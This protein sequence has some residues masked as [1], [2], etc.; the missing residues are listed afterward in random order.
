MVGVSSE[1]TQAER[2]RVDVFLWRRAFMSRLGPH[3][4]C[5]AVLNGLAL[6]MDDK[7]ASCFPSTKLLE[8]ETGLSER[9][10]CTHLEAADRDGWVDRSECGM[11]GQKWSRHQ[12][13]ATL[14]RAVLDQLATPVERAQEE[15]FD[16][17]PTG[18][19]T[20]RGSV[21]RG[22]GTEPLSMKALKEVQSNSTGNSTGTCNASPAGSVANATGAGRRV[23][24]STTPANGER[25]DRS[26][27]PPPSSAPASDWTNSRLMGLVRDHLYTPDRKA[28]A[29][30]D[31][32]RDMGII[33]DLQQYAKYS[34]G[35]IANAIQGLALL[36]DQ[37]QLRN[38]QGEVVPRGTKLTMRYLYH[39]ELGVRD[40]FGLAEDT[41]LATLQAPRE[42][43]GG[44]PRGLALVGEAFAKALPGFPLE[45]P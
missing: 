24:K 40:L 23:E 41:F 6:H 17:R 1:E 20:E 35:R 28:P 13:K 3:A 16:D 15:L 9:T 42:P 25:R 12:Y 30:Y 4:T 27:L 38:A 36:R 11:S 19:G 39:T 32:G 43:P 14:P 37:G 18:Q 7:G 2:V 10:V 33:Q 34:R 29:G 5:R 44:K 45:P 22:E 31:D 21:P 8:E 26:A